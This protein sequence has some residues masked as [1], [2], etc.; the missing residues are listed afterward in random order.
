MRAALQ[1]LTAALLLVDPDYRAERERLVRES[2]EARRIRDPA[3]LRA[4]RDTP[5]H[6]FMPNEVRKFAYEDRPVPI[7]YGQTISQPSLVAFMTETLDL[8]KDHRVL[9]IGTGSGYQAAVLSSLAREV[10]TIEIV[11]PLARSSAET[12][13]RLGYRNVFPREGNGYGGWPEKAPFDRIVLTAA[14][15]E[16]P[17]VL[18]DQLKPGGKLLAPV[19]RT[20]LEQELTLLEKSKSGKV[21]KRSV[22]PVRFVPMVQQPAR[23]DR[24]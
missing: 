9:E 24:D 1:L 6:E 12:L 5:R 18:V 19:G 14:P 13:K 2:I 11:P 15:P 20:V 4:M 3:V 7:G 23:H 16:I 10:Y 17:Q 8:S 21:S 22:L